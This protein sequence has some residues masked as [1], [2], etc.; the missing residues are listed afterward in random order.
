MYTP[1]MKSYRTAFFLFAVGL[2]FAAVL[3]AQGVTIWDGVYT[4]PQAD[5]G[6]TV[7]ADQC[8][9]CHGDEPVGSTMGPG[10]TGD[11]F[12]ADFMT[13]GELADKIR[14]TMPANNP[15]MLTPV[16][17]ADLVAFLAMANKWPA[18]AKELAS[19]LAAIKDIKI[20]KK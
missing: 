14:M 1:L 18:G 12:M 9:V 13:I 10:L 2:I 3:H 20:V 5:R 7:Y 4:E 11:G 17:T 8:S 16:Q 15:G 6:K 19:D